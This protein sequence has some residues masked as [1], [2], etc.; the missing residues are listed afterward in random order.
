MVTDGP[1]PGRADGREPF[2]PYPV[3]P[4]P[5]EVEATMPGPAA[6]RSPRVGWA[7]FPAAVAAL[8]LV[9]I[10]LPWGTQQG[11]AT[12]VMRGLPIAGF[13]G[14]VALVPL[15]GWLGEAVVGWR[16]TLA[17]PARRTDH[18]LPLC[19][20]AWFTV[21]FGTMG[22]FVAAMA[23]V[24]PSARGIGVW[25]YLTCM[26]LLVVGGAVLVRPARARD[27]ADTWAE[28]R[29]RIEARKQMRRRRMR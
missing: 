29:A 16:I 15:I 23:L 17:L 27:E 20:L 21:A 6:P 8:A 19:S 3:A 10:F 2:R 4:E 28:A 12:Q 11:F 5:A 18:D 22:V 7:W 14:I 25:W 9:G 26:V 13:M 1:G 24:Q